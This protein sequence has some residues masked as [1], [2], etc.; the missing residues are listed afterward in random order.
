MSGGNVESCPARAGLGL[1]PYR[2]KEHANVGSK[3][4]RQ[5]IADL[6]DQVH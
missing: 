4:H 6:V 2:Y 5:Q 1:I 3:E